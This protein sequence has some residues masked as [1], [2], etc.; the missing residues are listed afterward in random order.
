MIICPNCG[1]ELSDTAKFC[2]KCG[3]KIEFES[4]AETPEEPVFEEPVETEDGSVAFD[5]DQPVKIDDEGQEV[6]EGDGPE[7]IDEIE[8]ERSAEESEE[9]ETITD[10]DDRDAEETYEWGPPTGE[11][12][13]ED[14]T[15]M[16]VA[17]AGSGSAL[18]EI[19]EDEYGYGRDGV[20][21]PWDHTHEFDAEDISENKVMALAAYILGPIGV[22]IAL[23][24]AQSSPYA[25]FHVR[26]GLKLTVL[27]A[28]TTIVML[29]L[30][31]T[32]I[33]PVAATIFLIVLMIIRIIGF[34]HVCK[35]KAI[36]LPIVRSMNFLK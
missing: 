18:E 1:A 20:I 16:P 11:E 19:G 35:G 24:A 32:L 14:D 8:E 6:P 26:Q 5:W 9:S 29:L 36:E 22:I 17:F 33:V 12:G 28:L 31:W 25:G 7:E 27:E 21:P 23:L 3:T 2:R 34:V 30:C 13:S 10:T 15:M 4:M